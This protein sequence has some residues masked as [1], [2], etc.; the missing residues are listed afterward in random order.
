MSTDTD[1]RCRVCA[2]CVMFHANWS[3]CFT[4]ERAT[5]LAVATAGLM[6]IPA[7]D[8]ETGETLEP[9][10]FSFPCAVCGD[11]LGGY[12]YDCLVAIR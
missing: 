4:V 1:Y 7:A 11:P 8:D 9:G 10:F 5:E 12:R 6:I 2:D 3:D